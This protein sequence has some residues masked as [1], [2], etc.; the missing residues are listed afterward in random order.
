MNFLGV[1]AI[2]VGL[3]MDAFAVSVSAGTLTLK[4]KLKTAAVL[5]S[6]F[7]IFQALMPLVGWYAG[8][9]FAW[10]ILGYAHFAAFVILSLIGTSMIKG[11]LYDEDEDIPRDFT[12]L[13][14]ILLLA[15]ATSIDAL[16]VG[17]SFAVLE[18][19]VLLPALI[20]GITTFAFSFI[21]LFLGDK[22]GEKSQ[23]K[24]EILGG[25]ILILVGLK[26]LLENI[27]AGI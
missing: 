20:I 5:A 12:K 8:T 10:I 22:I 18:E 13:S 9:F 17:I 11:G 16:A 27:T 3:S 26:I 24:A 21:G 6:A 4:D 19:P 15:V 7:G 2:A 25:I 14:V 1:F 23:N